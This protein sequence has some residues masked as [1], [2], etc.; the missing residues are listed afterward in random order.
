M[1][2]RMLERFKQKSAVTVMAQLALERALDSRWINEVFERES[3]SQYT[4]ELLFSTTVDV[5]SLVS[6]G[7]APSLHAAAQSMEGQLSVALTS[8]YNKGNGVEPA[9]VRA[10]VA[11]SAEQLTPV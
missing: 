5:M 10:L 7:L 1:L 11:G 8:L 2:S 3:S 4:R 9:V 6:L